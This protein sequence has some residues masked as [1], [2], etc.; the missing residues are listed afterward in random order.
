MDKTVGDVM[1]RGVT[2]CPP[3]ALLSDVAHWMHKDDI[4][5]I[6]VTDAEGFLVGIVTRTDLV[7]LRVHE[8][9]REMRAEH[10]M[11]RAVVTIPPDQPLYAAIGLMNEHRIHRIVVVE[12]CPS[13]HLRPIGVVSQSDIVREMAGE[14]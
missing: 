10:A 3:D 6:P 7:T 1:H 8:L 9:W 11:T 5:A 12:P 14:Y 2:T 13:G 4:S